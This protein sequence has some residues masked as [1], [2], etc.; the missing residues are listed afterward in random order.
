LI[1]WAIFSTESSEHPCC[2][3]FYNVVPSLLMCYFVPGLCTSLNVINPDIS[4]L[5]TMAKSYLLPA[6]LVLLTLSIDLPAIR[7]LGSKAIIMFF[8]ATLGVMLGGPLAFLVMRVISPSTIAGDEVWRGFTTIAGSWIGGGANQAAMQ[9]IFEVPNEIYSKC[10]VVD[11]LAANL[12]MGFLLVG[13]RHAAK[14]DAWLQA[15]SSAIGELA[16]R[17]ANYQEMVK[18]IPS[19][20]DLLLIATVGSA[21][22]GLASV[23]GSFLAPWMLSLNPKLADFGLGSQFFW[24]V[25]ICTL[26]GFLLSLTPLRSLEGVGASKVGTIYLYILV[27]TIGMNMNF[28]AILKDPLLILVGVIWI[29][30]IACVTIIVAK[31][32]RSPFFFLAVGA[33]A[34][35]GGAA[36]APVI[37]AAF[38][39]ALASVGVL[40][41]VLG[42]AVGTYGALMCGWMLQAVHPA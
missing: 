29:F 40:L 20:Q 19:T 23:M 34:N 21:S 41:A 28:H 30:F 35:I 38:H 6:C 3:A 27:T 39:P 31:L 36:S 8:A 13:A 10:V 24:V 9:D 33:Q 22:T 25:V 11:A 37:A 7:N 18:R 15:D 1:L 42:Y 14:I 32:T 5:Y 17:L 2:K 26:I 12:W 16:T 4:K